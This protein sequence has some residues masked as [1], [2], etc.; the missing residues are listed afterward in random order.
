[1]ARR[2]PLQP[3]VPA[4]LALL[5]AAPLLHAAAG[6]GSVLVSYSFDEAVATGPDTFAIWQGARHSTTG[7]GRVSLSTAFHVSGSRSVEIRDVAGDGDFPEL[8]GYFPV[9]AAGRLFFHFAFLTTDPREELNIALAGPRFFQLEKDGIAFW[10]GTREGR[11]VQI[12]D[13][14]PKRLVPVEAF[15]WYTV[16]VAYDVAAG[17]Y[18]LTIHREGEERALVALR[19]QPNAARKAASAVNKF[20]FVGSPHHDLSNV[21]YYVDDVVIGTDEGGHALAPFVAPGRRKLFVDL[22]RDYQKLLQERPRCLPPSSPEDVGLTWDDLAR[23]GGE[24]L[25][26]AVQRMLTG[27]RVDLEGFTQRGQ[28]PGGPAFGAITDWNAGC[29]ALEAGDAAR[30]LARFEKA[31]A[32]VPEARIFTLS[33]VLALTGLK[34]FAEADERLLSLTA[35]R[36]D[37]RYAVASAYVGMNRGDLERAEAWLHDPAA[38]VLDREANPLVGLLRNGFSPQVLETLKR[39]MGAAFRDRLEETLVAEQYYYV[40]LWKGRYDMARDYALRMTERLRRAG[41]PAGAWTERAGDASFYGQDLAEARELYTQA[42]AGE[43]DNGALMALYLRLA[44]VAYLTGDLETEQALRQHYYGAL[45][46]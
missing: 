33:T 15:V 26:Y 18:A 10:L 24:G 39:Q 6:S 12:S 21:V 29:E 43:K 1:M 41:L 20:S 31:A 8:Q 44:D 27:E 46:E 9:R 22:F 45:P 23:L 11:L 5:L 30:A 17:T 28:G 37:P 42:I 40:Q 32:A 34:R 38:R 19:D 2:V 14:I 4:L 35:W 16:D 36:D 25:L 7:R 13:S 3:L